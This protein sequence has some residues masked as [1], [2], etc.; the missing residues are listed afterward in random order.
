MNIEKLEQAILSR[1]LTP[2]HLIMQRG[3]R[4]LW[5]VCLDTRPEKEYALI[6]YDSNGKALVLPSYPEAITPKTNFRIDTYTGR[7]RINSVIAQR[8][9]RLDINLTEER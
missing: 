4:V 7:V 8:D 5:F 2:I 1:N 6:V 9:S 3:S